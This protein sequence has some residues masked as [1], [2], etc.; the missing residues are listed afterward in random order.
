VGY[1]AL[2]GSG[3]HREAAEQAL[4]TAAAL[5]GQ[6]PRFAG[7]SLAAAVAMLDGPREVAVVGPAGDERTTLLHRT[8]LLGTAPGAAVALGDPAAPADVPLLE[9][10]PLVGGSPAAYVCRYFTCDAPTTDPAA[11]ATALG[12]VVPPGANSG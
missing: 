4:S 3:R 1:S 9:H 11:L 5:A 8:A 2:T 10:R 12:T 7:W 6:A